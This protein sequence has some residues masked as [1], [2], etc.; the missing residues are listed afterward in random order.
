MEII[1]E[2]FSDNLDECKIDNKTEYL[3]YIDAEVDEG[4]VD[5]INYFNKQADQP[6]EFCCSG[7]LEE[8]YNINCLKGLDLSSQVLRDYHFIR[9]PYVLFEPKYHHETDEGTIIDEEFYE[10][11]SNLAPDF[12]VLVTEND[13]E[14]VVWGDAFSLRLSTDRLDNNEIKYKYRYIFGTQLTLQAIFDK[15][16]RNF[17]L[18]DQF[19]KEVFDGFLLMTE[20]PE[21]LFVRPT[22]IIDREK[23]EIRWNY[24]DIMDKPE[25]VSDKDV[26]ELKQYDHVIEIG[27]NAGQKT[28]K[29]SITATLDQYRSLFCEN[30]E[31]VNQLTSGQ[32]RIQR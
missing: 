6:T 24:R 9:R 8:H 31:F 16:G 7:L 10:F 3:E 21:D 13:F 18:Y 27:E 22:M 30:E 5:I 26:F 12:G 1:D 28:T 32:H 4:M 23:E 15:I 11:K 20:Y 2:A 25:D 19:L 29:W 14:D 17:R